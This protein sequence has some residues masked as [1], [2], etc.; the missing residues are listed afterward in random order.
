[1]ER[2]REERNNWI[3]VVFWP[4]TLCDAVDG[5]LSGSHA[6]HVPFR[7]ESSVK[8][9]SRVIRRKSIQINNRG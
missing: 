3:Y 4:P 7:V 8:N 6:G 5:F 2:D 1:M 9:G